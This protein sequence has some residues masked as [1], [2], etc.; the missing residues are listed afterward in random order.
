MCFENVQ[1]PFT[2]KDLKYKISILMDTLFDNS[3]KHAEENYVRLC[4]FL[5]EFDENVDLDPAQ[6]PTPRGEQEA[7]NTFMA[8][9]DHIT[10]RV[11]DGKWYGEW[12]YDLDDDE[13]S[14]KHEVYQITGGDQK[15][16]L[17]DLDGHVFDVDTGEVLGYMPIPTCGYLML[18]PHPKS[19]VDWWS[20]EVQYEFQ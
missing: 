1:Q 9:L 16:H 4:D 2:R 10:E 18:I 12:K 15:G 8:W 5:K 13:D 11:E 19:K 3:D 20:G 17:K 7:L 6:L 14:V